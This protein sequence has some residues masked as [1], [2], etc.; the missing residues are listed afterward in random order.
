METTVAGGEKGDG[1]NGGRLRIPFLEH[2]PHTSFVSLVLLC[3]STVELGY[4]VVGS[5]EFSTTEVIWK[6]KCKV[7]TRNYNHFQY[8]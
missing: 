6:E 5:Q 1:N 3:A 8:S 4:F 2:F 7:G